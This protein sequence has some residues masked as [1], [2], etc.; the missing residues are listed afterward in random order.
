MWLLSGS[1]SLGVWFGINVRVHS[2]MI[3]FIAFTL[4]FPG[5]LGW[6]SSITSM[7]LLF[8]IVLLHEF[9]HCYGSYLVGGQPSQIL[10]TPL[11]GLASADAP[12]RPWPNFFTVLAGPLVNV[13]LCILAAGYISAT[14]RSWHAVPWNPL[15]IVR[16]MGSREIPRDIFYAWWI[17]TISYALLLF[18]LWPIF[19]LDGGQLLQSVLWAKFGYYR[20]TKFATITGMIGA[21]VMAMLGLSGGNLFLIMI[22]ISGFIWCLQVYRELKANGPWGYEEDGI[23]YAASLRGPSSAELRNRKRLQKLRRREASEQREIDAILAKVSAHG[24]QSL[25]FWEKRALHKATEHQRQ[26]DAELSKPRARY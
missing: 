24:M 3:L 15:A 25:T 4:L 8:G 13:L 10:M 21:G 12:R 19:P 17:F 5:A 11:G 7:A 23:V 26:R 18:N 22:A 9:G 6:H 20:A 2:S 14:L 1:V 16:A